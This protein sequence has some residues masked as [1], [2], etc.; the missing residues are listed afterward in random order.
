MC[1]RM[2]FVSKIQCSISEFNAFRIY[3]INALT[4]YGV[5]PS[6]PGMKG[7]WTLPDRALGNS[8][9]TDINYNVQHNPHSYGR[10]RRFTLRKVGILESPPRKSS[11]LPLAQSIA[12]VAHC[13]SAS[14][15][16]C[17]VSVFY[18]M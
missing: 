1:I 10:R 3:P 9:M 12:R 16:F 11:P 13:L 7:H 6:S 17:T 18:N 15:R 14:N 2:D 5:V 4:V 8:I